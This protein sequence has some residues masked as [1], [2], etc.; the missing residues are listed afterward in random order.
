MI[1]QPEAN[2]KIK[3]FSIITIIVMVKDIGINSQFVI[4]YFVGHKSMSIQRL[5]DQ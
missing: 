1:D 3:N 2:I 4:N 5:K